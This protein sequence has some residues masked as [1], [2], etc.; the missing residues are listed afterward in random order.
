MTEA[1]L[2]N[3]ACTDSEGGPIPPEEAV[4]YVATDETKY[5]W[6]STSE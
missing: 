1:E 2:F 6:A 3:A 5:L 4:T